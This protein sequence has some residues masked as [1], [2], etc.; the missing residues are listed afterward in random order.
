MFGIARSTR[1]A[2]AK[3]RLTHCAAAVI[4]LSGPALAADWTLKFGASETASVNDNIDLTVDNPDTALQTNANYSFDLLGKAHTYEIEFAPTLG[5]QR[6]FFADTASDTQPLSYYPAATLDLRKFGPRDTIALHASMARSD[7]NSNN[8]VQDVITSNQGYQLSSNLSATV[9]HKVNATNSLE[10]TTAATR[11]D[12]SDPS[13]D[14][15][16]SLDVTSTGTW[17]RK[18]SQLIDAN[19]A[20]GAEYYDP[21][22]TI[23]GTSLIMRS[24]VGADAKL[25]RRLS[26]AGNVGVVVEDNKNSGMTVGPT[27]NLSADY[28][29]KTTSFSVSAGLDLSPNTDGTLQNT[30]STSASV[31]HQVNDALSFVLSAYYSKQAAFGSMGSGTTASTATSSAFGIT[32]AL[33]Y[34]LSRDW[35]SSLS[36]QFTD[37]ME[38]TGSARSNAVNLTL[39]YG[40]LLIP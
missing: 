40:Y 22:S 29:L 30:L 23:D 9:T 24:T 27:F 37:S 7:A 38:T 14:L 16:P 3:I 26:V 19:F 34:Q 32:P 4:V 31:S 5:L 17:H 1:I 28:K 39:S 18:M 10:W 33:N 36:Y 8:L 11:V 2:G 13:T 15:V 6:T 35:N 21:N 20:L 25:S 12:Y